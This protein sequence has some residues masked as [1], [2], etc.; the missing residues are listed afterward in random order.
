MKYFVIADIHGEYGHLIK[1]IKLIRDS[2]GLNFK[3]GDTL[4][5]LGDR[6]DRGLDT[7][8]VNNFFYKLEK[9]YPGQV[10]CL[11]GNHE[12]MM[13]N[14]AGSNSMNHWGNFTHNGGSQTMRSYNAVMGDFYQR[15]KEVGHFDWQIS[16]PHFY[17]TDKYL[18]THAPI[19]TL[20]YRNTSIAIHNFRECPSTC[21]WS[22]EG[23]LLQ[24]WVDPDPTGQNKINVH[25][26]IHG[27]FRHRG[28]S[29]YVV[30]GIRQVGNSFIIDTGCGCATEGYLTCLELPSMTSYNSKGEIADGQVEKDK[31]E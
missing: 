24:N 13:L 4:V 18:F 9:R 3:A 1:L 19:P 31:I 7:F 16:Q 25:G 28:T 11:K 5:Q 27:I 23:D 2:G 26:H 22:Y 21:F 15:L 12:D 17:E 29:S 8:R 10:I 20:E 30:P 14:A 6:C